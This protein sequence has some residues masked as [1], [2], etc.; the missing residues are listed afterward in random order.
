MENGKSM[1]QR[2]QISHFQTDKN[3]RLLLTQSPVASDKNSVTWDHQANI[4][5]I[6]NMRTE[7]NTKYI[8]S[9]A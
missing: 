7:K 1:F 6:M 4:K 2:K 8:D 3:H 9:I 5:L